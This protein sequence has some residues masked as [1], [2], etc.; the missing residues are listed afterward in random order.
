M[1]RMMLPRRMKLPAMETMPRELGNEKEAGPIPQGA[2]QR[3]GRGEDKEHECP[4]NGIL[5]KSK[6]HGGP[7][8]SRE[9]GVPS[10]L[11]LCRYGG[12]NTT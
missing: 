9:E 11:Q 10:D 5:A 8:K 12:G 2:D 1:T 3:Q 4:E 6:A 7:I